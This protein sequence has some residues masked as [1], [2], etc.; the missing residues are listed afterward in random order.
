MP[1]RCTTR[2]AAAAER[3]TSALSPLPLPLV[4]RIFSLLPVDCRL[5]CAEVCRGWRSVLLERSLW[6]RLELT[7]ASGVRVPIDTWQFRGPSWDAL[8][9]C[10]AARAGGE[11]QSLRTEFNVVA[12]TTLRDVAAAN[13][14]ALREVHV[15]D[16]PHELGIAPNTVEAVLVAA[17]QLRI[18]VTSLSCRQA[19]DGNLEVACR[20]L[21]N[22]AP[23]GPLRLQHL[24]AYFEGG[25]EAGVAALAAA[26][27]AH[28]PLTGLTLRRAPLYWP[29][30]LDAVVDVALERRLQTVALDS[31]RLSCASAPGLARLLSGDALAELACSR[32]YPLRAPAA[33]VL[34]AALRASST[35]TSLKLSSAH[36]F[37]NPAVSAALL[38]ALTAHPSLRTLSICEN[39]MP[40]A[41]KPAAGALLGA[42]VAANA[43]AL[44]ALNVS[45]CDLRDAGLRPLFEAL[46]RNSHLRELDCS[47]NNLSEAFA[48]D[49]LLPAV[50]ANTSLRELQHTEHTW[51]DQAEA[52]RIV[53]SHAA[54]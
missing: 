28:A 24:Y 46:R 47:H 37:D 42:L 26:A 17:P 8:L 10:A 53:N 11:L 31:C 9:R 41:S 14:G 16:E 19:A 32:V 20:A 39:D 29:E 21:R 25:D 5:R 34:A 48:R 15:C 7:V 33:A 43:P 45:Y 18:F 6:T 13:A 23:F 4:L 12:A 49:V 3:A 38:G 30:A 2:S 27:A 51:P 22:E 35:L 44:T 52:G 36:V 40:E 50:R 1:P 54:A